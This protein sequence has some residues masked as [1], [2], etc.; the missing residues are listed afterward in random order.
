MKQIFIYIVFSNFIN[1][2][3]SDR[4]QLHFSYEVDKKVKEN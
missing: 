4:L 3:K 1:L 2:C